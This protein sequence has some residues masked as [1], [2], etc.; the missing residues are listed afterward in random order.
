MPETVPNPASTAAR[1][2]AGALARHALT[3]IGAYL[4]HHGWAEEGT[5]NAAVSP[6]AD[7]L[8]GGAI[9]VASASWSALRARAAHW[10][11]VQALYAPALP[12]SPAGSA[13]AQP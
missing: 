10:R 7:Y 11:W 1:S 5:V 2:I 9:V 4:V 6:I 12:R 3:L 8:V 13:P